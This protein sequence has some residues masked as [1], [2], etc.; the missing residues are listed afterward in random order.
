MEENQELVS[1]KSIASLPDG[2]RLPAEAA[3]TFAR[4]VQFVSL[5]KNIKLMDGSLN[6]WE[7][8]VIEDIKAKHFTFDDFIVA[9]RRM[10]REAVY[11]R[12]DYADFYA[13]ALSVASERL[14][15]EIKAQREEISKLAKGEI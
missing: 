9:A 2:S 14:G 1:L 13:K 11:N 15:K 7:Q 3:Q 5:V 10:I 8:C 6:A 4:T 12:L